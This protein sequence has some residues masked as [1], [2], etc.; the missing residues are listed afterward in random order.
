MNE[1]KEFA[2]LF[3]E[4]QPTK[5]EIKQMALTLWNIRMNINNT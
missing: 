3:D 2:I 1:T 5:Q 4:Y